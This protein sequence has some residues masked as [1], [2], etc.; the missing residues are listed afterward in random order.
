MSAHIAWSRILR[1][2]LSIAIVLLL[3]SYVDWDLLLVALAQA[4]IAALLLAVLVV[5][6]S[7]W[8]RAI[9]WR[10]LLVSTTQISILDL[11]WLGLTGITLNVILPASLGDVAKAYYA[12]RRTG[13][14]EEVLSSAVLDKLLGLLSVFILGTLAALSQDLHQY[15]YVT[16]PL[17]IVLF[18]PSFFPQVLPW[19]LLERLQGRLLR[20]RLIVRKL[21]AAFSVDLKQRVLCLLVSFVGWLVTSLIF[22]L[23]CLA[24][25]IPI[26]YIH[27]VALAPLLTI[28]RLVPITVSGLGTQEALIMYLF[29]QSGISV[30]SALVVSLSFTVVTTFIPGLVGLLVI[31][32]LKL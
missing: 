1:Y 29:S 5:V 18:I 9:R 31:W 17:G 2:G 23:L 11:F 16:V 24:F 25:S 27:V 26:S 10:I 4:R 22:Y 32:R 13:L 3:F 14:K 15:A 21:R 12:Y 19:T 20:D 30:T 8:I 6:V 7:L 28:A